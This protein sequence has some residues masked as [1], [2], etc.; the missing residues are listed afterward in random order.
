MAT[1][2]YSDP[3]AE[4][5]TA[6]AGHGIITDAHIIADGQLHRFYIE[7]HKKGSLNGAYTLHLDGIPAGWFT[8]FTTG[9]E[10]KWRLAGSERQSP[11]PE[12]LKRIESAKTERRRA[13]LI[14]EQATAEKAQY[15][16]GKAPFADLNNA[17]LVRKGIRPYGSKQG[18]N[19]SLILP[20]FDTD[21]KLVNL[22]F[23]N[24]DGTKRFLRGGKKAGCFWWIGKNTETILIAE[25]FATAASL[26]EATGHLT[27]VAYDAGNLEPVAKIIR[28]KFITAAI[29]ICADNDESGIGEIKANKAALAVNGLVA[30][31]PM[32]GDFND[33]AA[34]IGGKN[35]HR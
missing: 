33:W 11:D 8:D 24:A 1:Y 34:Q 10:V 12:V 35:D 6:M 18:R 20:L 29:I 4:F 2:P 22:Q 14:A 17:Y 9:V 31:P 27:F 7:G 19:G 26:H 16:F 32:T 28:S 21:K 25:G 30:M 13:K 5:K 3:I 15:V 23:V